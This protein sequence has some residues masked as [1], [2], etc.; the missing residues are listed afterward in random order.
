MSAGDGGSRLPARGSRNWSFDMETVAM[1]L[2]TITG[3]YALLHTRELNHG[4]EDP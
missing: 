3:A 1:H 2:N 4:H